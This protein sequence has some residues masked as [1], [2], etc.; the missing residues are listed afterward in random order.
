VPILLSFV[1]MHT[2][3][4]PLLP[5]RFG[6]DESDVLLVRLAGL[7]AMMLAPLAD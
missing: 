4:G 3:L 1:N 5:S 6:L 2:A 7:P